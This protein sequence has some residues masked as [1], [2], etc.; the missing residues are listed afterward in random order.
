M[1][2]PQCFIINK[3]NDYLRGFGGDAS[4]ERLR[5]TGEC[6]FSEVFD[7]GEKETRWYKLQSLYKL[8]VNCSMKITFFAADEKEIAVGDKIYDIEKLIRSGNSVSEKLEAFSKNF[9]SVSH[10]PSKELLITELRGRYLFFAIQSAS[11]DADGELPEILE[12]RLSFSPSMLIDMLPEIYR[13]G[14]NSFLERYL[15]IFQ[16]LYESLDEKIEHAAE[17]YV[18]ENPDLD[19]LRWLADT[20][21]IKT[22]DLWTEEQLRYILKNAPRLFALMGTKPVI[23]ELC[24]LY[25]GCSVEIVEYY[26]KEQDFTGK[27]NIIEQVPEDKLFI[28]PYTFTLIVRKEHL[29]SAELDG[30]Q[31]LLDACKPA[32]MSANIITLNEG[33]EDRDGNKLGENTVLFDDGITLV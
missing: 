31:R 23:A 3:K 32:W 24:G 28:D 21:G 4:D 7:S 6:Y 9:K 12:M 26:D 5:L 20:I 13:S 14:E 18:P 8:P 11:S 1:R 30:L 19:F 2:K 22:A 27:Y 10:S 25:L 29:S 33:A 16:S 15:A 17:A